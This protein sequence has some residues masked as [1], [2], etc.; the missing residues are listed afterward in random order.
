MSHISDS[1]S[2]GDLLRR[3]AK[4]FADR[5]AL[6]VPERKGFR[7]VSYGEMYDEAFRYAAALHAFGLRKG[8]R[9]CIVGETCVEW[10]MTDWGAQT[11]GVVT[12]PIYP[13]LPPD[14]AQYIAQDSGARLVVVS[15]AKQAAKFAE[16]S[17]LEIVAWI[18]GEG[19]PY[20]FDRQATLSRHEWESAIDSVGRAELATLIYTS[21][22]TGPPKGVM[23][24]HDNFISL[25]EHIQ[26]ALP[27]DEND[28]FLV[29]LPLSHVFARYAG[30]ILPMAIGATVAYAGSVASLASDMVRVQPTIMT[31]VPRF[32]ESV[33]A[34]IIDGV[35]K[36]PAMKRRLFALALAQGLKKQSGGFAPFAG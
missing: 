31:V 8:D 16:V 28:V 1:R 25:S 6:M 15:D 26:A 24:S 9:I 33:R 7:D 20:L 19:V 3:S 32:M 11:L 10:A 22:T 30:H 4:R 34:R 36:Q 2:L 35:K 13:T 21:G 14:Q 23:L 17:G 27:V 12:V 18:E 5:R 29:F